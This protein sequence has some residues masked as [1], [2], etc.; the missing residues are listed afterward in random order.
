MSYVTVSEIKTHLNI[1]SDFNDD[2]NYIG[3]LIAVAERV[4]QRH[5]CLVL[6]DIEDEDGN[7]PTPL[8]HAIMLYVGDLYNSRE[9]NAFGVTPNEIPHTYEYLL[10]LFKDYSP[11]IKENL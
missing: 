4:V 7:I 6:S 9:S 8:K 10:S 11:T 1:D 5:T 3:T 2:D